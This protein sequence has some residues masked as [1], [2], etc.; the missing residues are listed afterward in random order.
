MIH[1]HPKFYK[2]LVFESVATFSQA[3]SL[4]SALRL[5]F[6]QRKLF[7]RF[8]GTFLHEYTFSTT[9]NSPISYFVY[10]N[11]KRQLF[12]CIAL[13]TTIKTDLK[14]TESIL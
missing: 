13:L 7:L 2:G 12:D 4:V 11:A 9:S 8:K 3:N 6:N 1:K 5:P 14:L 10:H